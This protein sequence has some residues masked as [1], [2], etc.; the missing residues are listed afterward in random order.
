MRTLSIKKT[1]LYIA[2]LCTVSCTIEPPL[3]PHSIYRIKNSSED[4]ISVRIVYNGNIDIITNPNTPYSYAPHVENN[5]IVSPNKTSDVLGYEHSN[6]LLVD[7]DSTNTTSSTML[8]TSYLPSEIIDSLIISDKNGKVLLELA[9]NTALWGIEKKNA[10]EE[11][12]PGEY[13]IYY[14]FIYTIENKE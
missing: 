8:P 12:F 5:V 14:T 6:E 7:G 2:L 11:W 10:S 1:L 4:T 3:K 9:N 13:N